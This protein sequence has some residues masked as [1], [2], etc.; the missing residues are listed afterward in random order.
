MRP[1]LSQRLRPARRGS[2]T[3]AEPPADS[4]SFAGV[5]HA[6]LSEIKER[7]NGTGRPKIDTTEVEPSTALGLTGIACSGGGIRSASFC[8]GVLQ[9]LQ[10]KNVIRQMDYLSTVSGGGYIG[11]M[12][13][14]GMSCQPATPGSDG[15]F[16]FGRFNE[17]R[18][19][20]EVR[21]L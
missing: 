18:E 1:G 7:H 8:L 6:E 2:T 11:T 15:V 21:H 13:T 5:F 3:V 12:M 10:W 14:I 9:G 19:T 20:P 17:T 4:I 16:P